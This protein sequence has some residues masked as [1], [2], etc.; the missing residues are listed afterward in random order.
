MDIFAT[1]LIVLSIAILIAVTKFIVSE[2]K[3]KHTTYSRIF[4]DMIKSLFYKK[5]VLDNYYPKYKG[6]LERKDVDEFCAFL[7]TGILD[8]FDE[9]V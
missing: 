1:V 3:G 6:E 4:V 8:K 2:K 7:D 5:S 9:K